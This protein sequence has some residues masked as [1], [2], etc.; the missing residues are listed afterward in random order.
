MFPK[1]A[2]RD[3]IILFIIIGVLIGWVAGC[4]CNKISKH[5][6]IKIEVIK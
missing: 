1:N 5:I 4:T 2:M 6:K 3:V